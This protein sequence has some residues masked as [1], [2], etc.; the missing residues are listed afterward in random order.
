MEFR[1]LIL[2]YVRRHKIVGLVIAVLPQP[3]I[4][5]G[6]IRCSLCCSSSSIYVSSCL[7]SA[8][9]L[10]NQLRMKTRFTCFLLNSLETSGPPFKCCCHTSHDYF[11][12]IVSN[13]SHIRNDSM[14]RCF[15]TNAF[16]II[17]L[18]KWG[19]RLWSSGLWHCVVLYADTRVLED[20]VASISRVE[21]NM[22]SK[23]ERRE[24]WMRQIAKGGHF[25]PGGKTQS[26]EG[27]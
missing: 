19:L 22:V 9:T 10:T 8:E 1:R 20:H 7:Q 24:K 17:S 5:S 25:D 13:P 18:S 11:T 15:A 21:V 23:Q 12:I 14:V 27:R 4:I 2:L 16:E 26:S 6:P 3:A